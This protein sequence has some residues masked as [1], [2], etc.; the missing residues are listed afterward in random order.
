MPWSGA[1]VVFMKLAWWL[2]V[3]WTLGIMLPCVLEDAVWPGAPRLSP[4]T[5]PLD[6]VGHGAV[7]KLSP[8]SEL[9][10]GPSSPRPERRVGSRVL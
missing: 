9:G 7:S 8:N 1:H 5:Q 6:C 10:G 4:G 2:P 3:T